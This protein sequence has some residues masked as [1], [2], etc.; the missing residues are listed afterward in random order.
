MQTRTWVQGVAFLVVVAA[1]V[2]AARADST[3]LTTVDTSPLPF[4]IGLT[5]QV[6]F[7]KQVFGTYSV[8]EV[9]IH[10][11]L[12]LDRIYAVVDLQSLTDG[13]SDADAE[14]YATEHVRSEKEHVRDMLLHLHQVGPD[15]AELTEEERKIGALFPQ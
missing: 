5:P 4:P 9:V 8:N 13:M 14:E 15:S 11:A 6:R 3:T 7:W 2:P 10:D 12:H 1:V